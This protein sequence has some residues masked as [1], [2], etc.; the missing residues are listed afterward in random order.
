MKKSIRWELHLDSYDI[1]IF[2][3]Q[4]KTELLKLIN[5]ASIPT[6]KIGAENLLITSKLFLLDIDFRI[7]IKFD[8]EKMVYII[9]HP[10]TEVNIKTLYS[11]YRYIQLALE[12]KYGYYHNIFQRLIN[13]L[14]PINCYSC[15]AFDNI[16]VEHYII[17]RFGIEEAIKFI[18]L[19]EQKGNL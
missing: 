6:K 8:G 14:D 13:Y 1:D 16:R 18:M 4:T 5:K 19:N 3:H 12:K 11:Q 9:I 15:W 2:F 17:E 10:D 7:F